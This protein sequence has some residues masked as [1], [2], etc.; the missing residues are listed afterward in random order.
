[1]S[2][3]KNNFPDPNLLIEKYGADSLRFYLMNSVVMQA[4][5]LNFSEKDVVNIHRKVV[6]ILWNV[7]KYF[8]TYAHAA[9]HAGEEWKSSPAN[10]LDTWIN[11]RTEEL[12]HKVT[13]YLNAYDTVHATRTIQ[14][15]IDD[16][17][18]WYLRR[19][20][21]RKDPAF[22]AV[23]RNS[24]LA[25]SKVIA[26]FMP[27]LA[28]ELY[29]KLRHF[30]TDSEVVESVHLTDWP[31]PHFPLGAKERARV[32]EAMA[33]VRRLASL[34]LAERAV[35]GVKVR[36]P[37][38][39]LKIKDQKMKLGKEFTDILADEVNVKKV[40]FD[41]NIEREVALDIT[42]TPELREEGLLR[43]CVRTVQELRQ[44]AGLSPGDK[45]VLLLDLPEDIKNAVLRNEKTL[46]SNV[47]AT[48]VEY[49]RSDKFSAE[50][51]TKINGQDVWIGIRKV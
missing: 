21:K 40:V 1:M 31:A 28:E 37:L 29:G 43:E 47:G 4:D 27:F 34:G 44:T 12:I 25:A 9:P 7:Y 30:G 45:I 33:E 11:I 13:E 35:A 14:E 32:T 36:Q 26:P 46:Q 41:P 15:Y 39:S 19:S 17:S 6:L 23:L 2:K 22:F 24:L 49:R 10:I 18:T 50:E 38:A 3:S 20:R 5:N 42:I 8:E 16:L 51:S 48:A